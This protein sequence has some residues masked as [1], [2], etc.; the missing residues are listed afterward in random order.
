MCCCVRACFR[1]AAARADGSAS[2]HHLAYAPTRRHNVG[3]RGPAPAPAAAVNQ[4]LSLWCG[5]HTERAAAPFFYT[6]PRCCRVPCVPLPRN[7]VSS[8]KRSLPAPH[9]W[10]FCFRRA[11]GDPPHGR[12]SVVKPPILQALPSSWLDSHGTSSGTKRPPLSGLLQQAARASRS[13]NHPT[14]KGPTSPVLTLSLSCTT[15][16]AWAA[17]V[18]TYRPPGPNK[19]IQGKHEATPVWLSEQTGLIIE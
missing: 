10:L 18:S 2:G 1:N 7:N 16:G 19:P 11:Q 13:P 14:R 5:A 17:M 15:M 6:R 9:P 12:G 8:H 4:A 3:M